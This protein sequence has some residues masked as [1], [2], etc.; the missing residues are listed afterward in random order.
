MLPIEVGGDDP[1]TAL[2]YNSRGIIWV[3]EGNDD[4]ALAD[5]KKAVE[6]MPS[7][8]KAHYNIGG[9]YSRRH[10]LGWALEAFERAANLGYEDAAT[11]YQQLDAQINMAVHTKQASL[12]KGQNPDDPAKYIDLAYSYYQ[13]GQYDEAL[14][15][16]EGAL[17][18]NNNYVRA[19]TVR[20]LVYRAREQ[21]EAALHEL[22]RAIEV[23]EKYMEAYLNRA[24]LY[25]VQQQH[26]EAIADLSTAIKLF[27]KDARP[28]Y[29]LGNMLLHMGDLDRA[30]RYLE[31]A[32]Q[33]DTKLG[34][35]YF[36]LGHIHGKKGDWERALAYYERAGVLGDEDAVKIADDLRQRLASPLGNL[37]DES[38]TPSPEDD[39]VMAVLAGTALTIFA[40]EFGGSRV[41]MQVRT[42]KKGLFGRKQQETVEVVKWRVIKERMASFDRSGY[43]GDLPG[44][45]LELPQVPPSIVRLSAVDEDSFLLMLMAEK[46]IKDIQGFAAIKSEHVLAE[47]IALRT[48]L[49]QLVH[50]G[51]LMVKDGRLQYSGKK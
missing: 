21:Y 10:Q 34:D 45:T 27:P 19:Y 42:V 23:D 44:A 17:H 30:Q 48:A 11:A 51:Y 35:A 15:E 39:E 25:G 26:E 1:D 18:L 5:F 43:M 7:H 38:M 47:P 2:S 36:D 13:S 46:Q 3:L 6:L 31:K 41:E 50:D 14:T 29:S 8:A 32:T 22:N 37:A 16:I 49:S 9:V 33:L 40:A 20:A 12:Q 28:V 24:N 4:R